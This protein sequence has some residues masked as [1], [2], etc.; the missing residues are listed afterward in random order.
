MRHENLI[1]PDISVHIVR[2]AYT[3]SLF[4][5]ARCLQWHRAADWDA[6]TVQCAALH[7]MGSNPWAAVGPHPGKLDGDERTYFCR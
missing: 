2:V 6:L 3:D 4:F 5:L 7:A 1:T